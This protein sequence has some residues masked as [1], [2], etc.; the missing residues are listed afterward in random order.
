MNTYEIVNNQSDEM[1]RLIRLDH[2]RQDRVG[3]NFGTFCV[4]CIHFGK[5]ENETPEKSLIMSLE[6]MIVPGN[7]PKQDPFAEPSIYGRK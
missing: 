7:T 3:C 1:V 5:C 2:E 4:D 6:Y